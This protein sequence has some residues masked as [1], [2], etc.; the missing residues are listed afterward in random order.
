MAKLGVKSIIVGIVDIHQV[1][2]V[3]HQSPPLWGK[4]RSGWSK[5]PHIS[6]KSIILGYSEMN[7]DTLHA[8]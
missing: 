2:Q 5:M 6:A 7:S 3:E 4:C 1:G 8:C